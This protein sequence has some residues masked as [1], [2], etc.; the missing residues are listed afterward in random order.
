[1]ASGG[2]VS[3]AHTSDY[4]KS[5]NHAGKSRA[6]ILGGSIAGLSAAAAISQHFD[7]VLILE[8]E[9]LP[10]VEVRNPV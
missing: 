7:E 9:S 3:Q 1:M 8:R 10:G 6:L 5:G 4:A 2:Q